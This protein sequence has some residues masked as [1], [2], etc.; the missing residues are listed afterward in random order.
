MGIMGL[1]VLT[2]ISA[3]QAW[4]FPWFYLYATGPKR[5]VVPVTVLQVGLIFG[6]GLLLDR[7]CYGRWLVSQYN[8]YVWNFVR[9]LA[10]SHGTEEALYYVR[11]VGQRVLMTFMPWFG[12]GMWRLWQQGATGK[13]W[14]PLVLFAGPMLLTASLHGHKEDRFIAPAV[15]VLV[16]YCGYGMQQA[17]MQLG[18]RGWVWRAAHVGVL[19][20]AVVPQLLYGLFHT[21]YR[22]AGYERALKRA[23]TIRDRN[24]GLDG[25]AQCDGS[26]MALAPCYFF[27]GHVFVN[28][29]YGYEYTSCA[30]VDVRG[31][32]TPT[33]EQV[34]MQ[35]YV[36]EG[37]AHV[38]I[39]NRHVAGRG[40]PA[41]VVVTG[42][43][44][45]G[46]NPRLWEAL[47]DAGYEETEVVELGSARLAR[48]YREWAW[49]RAVLGWDPASSADVFHVLSKR[50][51]RELPAEKRAHIHVT[52][53]GSVWMEEL[54]VA[55]R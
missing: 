9:G 53:V 38:L 49:V 40:L 47:G 22:V 27:P 23:V 21:R 20:A 30:P 1:A 12:Y 7:L 28:R 4:I 45:A 18:K 16:A 52:V 11:I 51:A 14:F 19:G 48:W 17:Q 54:G 37:Y 41:V 42:T 32:Y 55:G 50:H 36:D 10:N 35:I 3:M 44:L 8:F 33:E 13:H 34:R 5:R 43:V 2:R 24:E 46:D 31:H 29:P 39:R 15:P 26:I 6:L 25:S